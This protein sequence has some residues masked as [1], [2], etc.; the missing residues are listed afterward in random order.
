MR[1]NP[2]FFG[3]SVSLNPGYGTYTFDIGDISNASKRLDYP[4]LIKK[5]VIE[6]IQITL[7]P[8]VPGW[9]YHL[10]ISR[11]GAIPLLIYLLPFHGGYFF[12]DPTGLFKMTSYTPIDGEID[13]GITREFIINSSLK[14]TSVLDTG[15][16]LHTTCLVCY[17]EII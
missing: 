17:R 8:F 11:D 4:Q 16:L 13:I 10:E 7:G 15:T 12:V 9:T 14:L 1:G 3:Q 5:V 2:D 6:N